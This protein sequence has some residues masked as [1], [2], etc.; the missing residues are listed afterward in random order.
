M[1]APPQAEP[2]AA[3]YWAQLTPAALVARAVDFLHG[4][5]GVSASQPSPVKPK[6]P[7]EP[8]PALVR[9]PARRM[10]A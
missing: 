5:G 10:L 1:S 6:P 8:P 4:A 3:A 2:P 7:K 9:R